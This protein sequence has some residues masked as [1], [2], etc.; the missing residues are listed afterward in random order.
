M[1]HSGS[2]RTGLRCREMESPIATG[3]SAEVEDRAGGTHSE[4]D[5]A[6]VSQLNPYQEWPI[7]E[8]KDSGR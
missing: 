2:G 7:M 3:T 8:G 1:S 5:G 4:A 6:S